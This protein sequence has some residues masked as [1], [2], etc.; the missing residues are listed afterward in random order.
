MAILLGASLASA[1]CWKDTG[2]S[3]ANTIKADADFSNPD[4]LLE[5]VSPEFSA[6]IPPGPTGRS[7]ENLGFVVGEL[8]TLAESGGAGLD[9]EAV[10]P[11]TA[12]GFS[13]PVLTRAISRL[14]RKERRSLFIIQTGQ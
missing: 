14:A 3:L 9:L 10:A 13:S 5:F 4:W 7:S 1:S 8:H 11:P 6:E 2:L 12:R